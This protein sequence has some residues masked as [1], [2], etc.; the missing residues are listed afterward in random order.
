MKLFIIAN[1]EYGY[2]VIA[3][4]T[5][6]RAKE[7]FLKGSSEITSGECI[8]EDTNQPEGVVLGSYL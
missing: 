6:E 5:L 7:I 8:A 2:E 4:E 3:A 1:D